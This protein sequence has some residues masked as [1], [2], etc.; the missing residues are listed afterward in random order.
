MAELPGV[1]TAGMASHG[2]SRLTLA[3]KQAPRQ[4]RAFAGDL[5][6]YLSPGVNESIEGSNIGRS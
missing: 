5:I 4:R 2:G 1:G 6:K 3:M